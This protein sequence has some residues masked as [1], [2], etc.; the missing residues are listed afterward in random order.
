MATG[1][2]AKIHKWLALLMAVQILLWF[3]SGLFFAWFPIER[4]RSEHAKA[5]QVAPPVP[6]DEAAAGL[7][8]L[9]GAG[10]GAAETVEVR[11][12]LGRPVALVSGHAGRPV[13]YD[14]AD[15]RRLSPVP[16]ALAAQIAEADHAGELRAARVS[17]IEAETTEYRGTLP[18]WRVDFE[19]G[20]GRSVYVAAD[21][22]QVTARRS[23][24]WR[25]YDFLWGLHIMDWRGHEDFNSWLLVIAT[26]LATLMS[27]AGIVLLPSRL[28]LT[29]WLR[30]RRAVSA[31][32][33]PSGG[34]PA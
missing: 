13:L 24:L 29:G 15:A 10:V 6:L 9:R 17:R 5:E 25:A 31:A 18:A 22:G 16:M 28:G 7:A 27:V 12:L 19:D 1:L 4:V 2:W 26:L 21:T 34:P 33:T 8:R 3:A 30:R 20:E 32:R 11:R 23:T 14:L